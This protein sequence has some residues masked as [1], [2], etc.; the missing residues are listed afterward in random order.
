MH[1]VKFESYEIISVVFSEF[2]ETYPADSQ[3]EQTL[4]FKHLLDCLSFTVIY[5]IFFWGG[6][7]YKQ[8]LQTFLAI[9]LT[10]ID[11]LCQIYF[12]Q[13]AMLLFNKYIHVV[14]NIST[15]RKLAKYI[16]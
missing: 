4:Y 15:V 8:W 13:I 14:K 6:G 2:K 9:F 1:K 3:L 10:H 11:L 5:R 7:G 12:G 16:K